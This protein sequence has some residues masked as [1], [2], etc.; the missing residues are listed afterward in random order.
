M[1]ETTKK[2]LQVLFLV[3]FYFAI[4]FWGRKFGNSKPK[5]VLVVHYF[6]VFFLTQVTREVTISFFFFLITVDE[7]KKNFFFPLSI[8]NIQEISSPKK[9]LTKTQ[10][11]FEIC[12]TTCWQLFHLKP[13]KVEK[14]QC[15][16]IKTMFF[17]TVSVRASEFGGKKVCYYGEKTEGKE[18]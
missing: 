17:T 5:N 8:A 13:K 10:N 12:A 15:S 9:Y 14:A 18:M 4:L 2:V 1:E 7:S 11:F 16:K 6:F 3:F